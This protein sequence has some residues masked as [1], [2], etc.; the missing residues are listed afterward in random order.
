MELICPE[1]LGPLV[2]EGSTT[3]SCT[4]HHGRYRV[5]Y[6]VSEVQP[7]VPV[8]AGSVCR[9]HP[10]VLAVAACIRCGRLMCPTCNFDVSG[11]HYCAACVSQATPERPAAPAY[12][13]P[14][15]AKCTIH[16]TV[17]AQHTCK[18]CGA[19]ICP[20]CAF[21]YPGGVYLCPACVN[22]PREGVGKSRKTQLTWAYILTA[23]A[24]LGTAVVCSGVFA[25]SIHDQSDLEA[26]GIMISFFIFLPVLIG[27]GLSVSTLDRRLRNPA[28]VWGAIIWSGILLL[29]W[30]L[31]IIIGSFK[32]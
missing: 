4:F 26:F 2:F 11:S 25:H 17:A 6:A 19:Y 3:V 15:D 28:S 1:C 29:I 21:T 30:V 5:L 14:N 23:W 18:Q 24:T 22:R 32:G 13:L 10:A 27:T 12:V 31:L 7:A 9:E 16:P 20:T 8:A